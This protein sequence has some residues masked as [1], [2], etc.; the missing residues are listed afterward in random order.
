MRKRG[1]SVTELQSLVLG[2]AFRLAGI[3]LAFISAVYG[4]MELFGLIPD[5][6]ENG[7]VLALDL[8]RAQEFNS[9]LTP[10]DVKE[11]PGLPAVFPM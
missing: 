9:A 3:M 10:E 6:S 1:V 7:D 8:D 5:I 11:G 4:C 2:S